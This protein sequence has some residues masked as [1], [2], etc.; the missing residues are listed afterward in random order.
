MLAPAEDDDALVTRLRNGEEVQVAEA[1]LRP[2]L[3]GAVE[4]VCE[5]GATFLAPKLV[6]QV[7][8]T[9]WTKDGKL[10]HPVFQGLRDD[11]SATEVQRS[12]DHAHAP[13]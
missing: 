4:D 13:V 2:L 10:R 1:R 5:R 11:K 9:E 12:S 7:S 3:Q 8:F 6:A